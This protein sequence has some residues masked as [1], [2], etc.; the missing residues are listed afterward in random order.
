VFIDDAMLE[1]ACR[2]YTRGVQTS[3]RLTDSPGETP[4]FASKEWLQFEDANWPSVI[5]P[6]LLALEAALE[7]G[8]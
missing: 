5:Q 3:F 8:H 7:E 4:D 2:A 6:M 1:R